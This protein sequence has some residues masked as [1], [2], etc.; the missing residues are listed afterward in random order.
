MADRGSGHHDGG[1]SD[2]E[3]ESGEYSAAASWT[4]KAMDFL[5][6]RTT[7]SCSRLLLTCVQGVGFVA[8]VQR[9][10]VQLSIAVGWL[11]VPSVPAVVDGLPCLHYPTCIRADSVVL[12]VSDPRSDAAGFVCVH[13]KR[14]QL[15]CFA[16]RFPVPPS[17]ILHSIR[18]QRYGY[19]ILHRSCSANVSKTLV[20]ICDRYGSCLLLIDH[21]RILTSHAIRALKY[22]QPEFSN[23]TLR[24]AQINC[25]GHKPGDPCTPECITLS[26]QW[27]SCAILFH[28]I[29]Y[30][31]SRTQSL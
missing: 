7:R 3:N 28:V 20:G 21:V 15:F 12:R 9:D 26:E 19:L 11:L 14:S 4:G 25:W 1:G 29:P 13:G 27:L 22:Q 18:R 2:T 24:L 6:V 8:R 10:I 30:L 17:I 5:K 23:I 16:V 31:S